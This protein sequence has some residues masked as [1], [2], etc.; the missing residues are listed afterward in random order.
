MLIEL[1]E[2]LLLAV[3]VELSGRDL[4]RLELVCSRFQPDDDAQ[5]EPEPEPEPLDG[6]LESLGGVSAGQPP[7]TTRQP[8]L[9]LPARAAALVLTA[10]RTDSWRVARRPASGESWPYILDVLDRR[11][12]GRLVAAGTECTLAVDR[13]GLLHSHGAGSHG[14]LGHDD[15]STSVRI[16]EPRQL[17]R[18]AQEQV[19]CVALRHNHAAAV[20]ANGTLFTWGGDGAGALGCEQIQEERVIDP[21]RGSRIWRSRPS[22]EPVVFS[23]APQTR[24]ALVAVGESHTACLTAEGEV[25]SWGYAQQGALG[26]GGWNGGAA[27]PNRNSSKKIVWEPTRV[28]ALRSVGRFVDVSCGGQ[29]TAAVSATGALFMWGTCV[30]ENATSLD[31]EQRDRTVR[32]PQRIYGFSTSS[33]T[34]IT[35]D[36]GRRREEEEEEEEHEAEVSIRTVSCGRYHFAAVGSWTIASKKKRGVAHS[37][38]V[39]AEST[40]CEKT[41]AAKE[42]EEDDEED[43]EIVAGVWT[44]GDGGDGQLGHGESVRRAPRP[45]LVSSSVRPP[46]A[47]TMT[48]AAPVATSSTETRGGGGGGEELQLLPSDVCRVSCGES[49]TCCVSMSGSL[50][51]WGSNLDGQLGTGD[52]ADRFTPAA[53]GTFDT[54]S[55]GGGHW[56]VDDPSIDRHFGRVVD[57]SCGN[58]HT[59]I[60][61][62]LAVLTAGEM[63]ASGEWSDF[64]SPRLGESRVV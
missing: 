26:H 31:D 59:V 10:R 19:A 21:E 29:T 5:P 16:P 36:D 50:Y 48:E 38:S 44:W 17:A 57:V 46:P 8:S 37:S 24:V 64:P 61:T 34:E 1:D 43:E 25:Y 22:P 49:H 63:D 13:G 27:A 52:R 11:L 58:R 15:L 42:K 41:E 45:R 30:N 35:E 9:S 18:L 33:A 20:T 39:S 32:T 56:V 14:Q 4:G 55:F 6:E 2:Q 60:R 7:S 40:T 51:A 12:A 62:E 54:S 53:I 47:A 3:L 28:E 23:S